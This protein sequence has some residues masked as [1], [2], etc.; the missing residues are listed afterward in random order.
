M[1]GWW[2]DAASLFY[3]GTPGKWLMTVG[4]DGVFKVASEV[5][6]SLA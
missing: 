3:W 2:L 1:E 4:F 5:R 6:R